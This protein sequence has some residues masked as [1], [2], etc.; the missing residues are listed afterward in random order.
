MALSWISIV[1]PAHLWMKDLMNWSVLIKRWSLIACG[2]TRDNNE[3]LILLWKAPWTEA[4]LVFPKMFLIDSGYP[5]TRP[6]VSFMRMFLFN[7]GSMLI[8][9]GDPNTWVLNRFPYL[10]K[11]NYDKVYAYIYIHI[12]TRIKTLK[13]KLNIL[14]CGVFLHHMVSVYLNSQIISVLVF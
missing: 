7:S 5:G 6:C 12:Y 3:P 2:L 10:Q 4:I 9:V 11:E 1:W 14:H 8:T 13:Q